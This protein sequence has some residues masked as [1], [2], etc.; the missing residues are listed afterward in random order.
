MINYTSKEKLILFYEELVQI[1]QKEIP[2]QTDWRKK[3]Q[4]T[5]KRH[6]WETLKVQINHLRDEEYPSLK[7]PQ[8]K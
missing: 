6:R 5:E 7:V 4:M 8:D 1:L 2:P 3:S